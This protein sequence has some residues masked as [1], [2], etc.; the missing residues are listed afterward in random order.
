M[1]HACPFCSKTISEISYFETE[2]FRTIYNIA[3]I[4]P[5]HS[6]VIPKK[7]VESLLDFSDQELAELMMITRDSIT[8]LLKV[9]RAKGFNISLQEKE[10]AGQTIAHFHLHLIPR[11]TKDLPESGDWYT[12][13]EESQHRVID[14]KDRPKL[15]GKEIIE[16]VEN[17]KLKAA[18]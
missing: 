12:K 5:G 4:L 7:H 10:E 2:N 15:S 13:L 14:S 17:I 6:L 1:N 11:Q 8:I 18:K 16:I 9:F 3:P